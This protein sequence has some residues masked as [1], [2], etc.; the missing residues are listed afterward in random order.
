MQTDKSREKQLGIFEERYRAE[1][2]KSSVLSYPPRWVTIGITGY[3]TNK[4]LFCSYHAKASGEKSKVY[5]IHYHMSFDFFKKTVD[6]CR[7]AYVPFVHVC[8]TGEPFLNPD[9]LNMLDYAA[10]IYGQTSI[11]TNFHEDLFRR[12]DLVNQL[13]SREKSLRYVATDFLSGESDEHNRIKQGSSFDF[14]MKCLS[15]ISEK[16]DIK[17]NIYYIITKYNYSSLSKLVS[18]LKQNGIRNCVINVN[19]LMSYD[20][21]SYTSS[22]SV[23]VSSDTLI[24]DELKRAISVCHEAGYEIYCPQPADIN[25]KGCDVFWQKF[26]VWPVQGNDPA[27][28][29]E[30]IIPHACR[31]VVLGELNS[32]GYLGDYE[33]LMD[34]WNN[35]KIVKIRQNI[36]D[37]IYPDDECRYCV[38]SH[39]S[40]YK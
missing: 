11:Q 25:E 36:I 13:I 38:Y 26:Q 17:L 19:N 6:M 28:Y 3:C 34:A 27:R 12:M 22:D 35:E 8:G 32:L 5:K 40:I 30:N 18:L 20:F 4:C 1:N 16:S 31:A 33:D 37:G 21:D 7:K 23:Y 39:R 10:Q 29:Q 9:A 24:T 2:M 14:T 15:E